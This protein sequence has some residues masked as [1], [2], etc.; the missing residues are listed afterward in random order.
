VVLLEDHIAVPD[1][2]C[3]RVVEAFEDDDQA[4]A[5]VGSVTNGAPRVL[6]RASFLLTWAPFLAPMPV[7]PIDR[8]PP[9][10]AI[11]FRRSALPTAV[12]PSGWLEYELPVALRD[13][14]QMIV[15]ERVTVNHVQRVGMRG[16]ALQYHAGR[17]YSGL[18]HEPRSS[19][20]RRERLRQ[21]AAI[22]G[23]L[24]A[25]T[26]AGLRRSGQRESF[27]C[28]SAVTAFAVCNALGQMV[29]VLRGAGS[30][31]KHLE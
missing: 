7:V 10:G 13:R 26:R 25:Q 12:P 3:A 22:P 24:L 2:Y 15:A 30:S 5:I 21:A 27:S 8:C 17:G 19:L 14:G 1:D 6:D 31:P 20:G 9:P 16:F 23:I 11:A 29:G 4:L 28:M 18:E